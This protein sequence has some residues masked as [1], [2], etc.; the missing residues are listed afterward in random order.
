MHGIVAIVGRPNVGK[1]TL[2]NRLIAERRAIVD[3]IPGVTRDRIWGKSHWNG[4]EFYVV[5]TGGYIPE[6]SD[7]FAAAIRE[8]VEIALEDA[9]VVIFVVD[10]LAGVVPFDEAVAD[11][12]RKR[13]GSRVIVAANKSDNFQRE[14]LS[15]EFYAL[16]LSPIIPISA[17][18]GSG[19]GD[20]L[21]A[22][23]ARLPA[24]ADEIPNDPIAR[25][26]IVGRPNVGK[27]SL[28]NALIGRTENIVTPIAGTTRD[29]IYTR[30]QQFGYDFWLIDTA[31]LRRK[32][33]I[34][35]NIEF[36]STLRTIKAI[37]DCDVA[38]LMID[39]QTGI[40]AQDLA[41]L[42]LIEQRHKGIV[43]LINKWDLIEK[44]GNIDFILRK[45]VEA[46]IAPL[47][48]VPIILISATEKIRIL[49]ALEAAQQVFKELRRKIPTRELN[50]I[51]LPIIN[52][53]PPP[54]D[55]G[56]LVR[57]RFI[58]QVTAA[59][60]TFLFFANHPKLVVESY[61]RFLEKQLRQHFG[62]SG[63]P[64]RIFFRQK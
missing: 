20:L 13:G 57:I 36:Y 16:G 17:I 14:A 46:R 10:V 43:I 54:S 24:I 7:V 4:K 53:T 15:A 18:S 31:G 28:V 21:D 58:T 32:A 63:C 6:S 22:V 41:I 62:F 40:E 56:K 11:L 50:E 59:A 9:D 60:P 3:D 39:A 23:V 64:V 12:L 55:R 33:K 34:S 48:D 61:K 25:I 37:E 1:S 5:D 8:Q 30:Y 42:R 29:S 38:M 35:D 27:S 49:K 45:Q 19:T 52:Q 47:T 26:A 51:L 2:F 44:K